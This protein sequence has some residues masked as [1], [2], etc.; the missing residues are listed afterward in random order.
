[1]EIQK[2][3]EEFYYK[4]K[5]KKVYFEKETKK[6]QKELA[7]RIHSYLF[8]ASFLNILTTQLFGFASF[9]QYF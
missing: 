4:I 2:K 9:P 6:Y 3:E 5:E 7:S 8:N 1:L